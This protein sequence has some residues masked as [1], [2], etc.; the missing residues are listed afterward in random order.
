MLVSPEAAPAVDEELL[1]HGGAAGH[2]DQGDIA[3]NPEAFAADHPTCVNL[4][5]PD[6]TID[7]VTYQAVVRT[8]QPSLKA[9][10]PQEQPVIPRSII[11]R[12]ADLAQTRPHVNGVPTHRSGDRTGAGADPGLVDGYARPGSGSPLRDQPGTLPAPSDDDVLPAALGVARRLVPG[13]GLDGRWNPST[14]AVRARRVLAERARAGNPLQLEAGVLAEIAR[15]P[16]TLTPLR[17][18]KAEQTSVVRR[19]RDR[20]GLIARSLSGRFALDTDKQIDWD[21]LPDAYQA[22]TI[23]RGHLLT[24]KQAGAPPG[25]RRGTCSYSLP[26]APGQQKLAVSVLDWNRTEV[27]SRGPSGASP[28]NW[29]P[30]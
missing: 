20:V 3:A 2:A 14:P 25:S 26:L 30:T 22:T 24:I 18:I 9:A 8:T 16:E 17:L 21:E 4:T 15:R 28:R 7:E 10:T 19:F 6:R 27:A 5:V 23:A 29:S 13:I 11:D 12:I 1:V